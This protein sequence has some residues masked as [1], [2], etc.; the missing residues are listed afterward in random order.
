MWLW[1]SFCQ[2]SSPFF[3]EVA[4]LERSQTIHFTHNNE[5]ISLSVYVRAYYLC[6][7]WIVRPMNGRTLIK[8]HQIKSATNLCA[9]VYLLLILNCEIN[10]RAI[11]IDKWWRVYIRRCFRTVSFLIQWTLHANIRSSSLNLLFFFLLS[12]L[13]CVLYYFSR[14]CRWF[15]LI[16]IHFRLLLAAMLFVNGIH[17]LT[18]R[19]LFELV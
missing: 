3:V 12:F 18:D 7:K 6:T 15:G 10:K 9:A 1:A 11:E 16:W 17:K 19:D 14:W 2:Y 5:W 8:F 13:F 4:A